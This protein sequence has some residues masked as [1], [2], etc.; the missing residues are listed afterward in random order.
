MD[1]VDTVDK[2]VYCDCMKKKKEKEKEKKRKEK[3]RKE[4][5]MGPWCFALSTVSTVSN[6]FTTTKKY[7][8]I[9]VIF[10]QYSSSNVERTRDRRLQ[11][12]TRSNKVKG[13]SPLLHR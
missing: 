13:R 3:K 2:G 6:H 4:S 12:R 10:S 1:T 5:Y 9:N 8:M 7:K 11:V